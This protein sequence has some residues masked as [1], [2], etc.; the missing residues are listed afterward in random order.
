MKAKPIGDADDMRDGAAEAVSQPRRQQHDVVRPGV[1]NIT[2]ANTMKA[3]EQSTATCSPHAIFGKRLRAPRQQHHGDAADNDD[4][5]GQ[6]QRAEL[7]R[8]TRCSKQ[9]SRRTAPA[10]RTAPPAPP[11][12]HAAAGPRANRRCWSTMAPID[13]QA[14]ERQSATHAISDCQVGAGPLTT[15]SASANSG[16]AAVRLSQA[17]RSNIGAPLRARAAGDC[18]RQS[19]S[20]R[21]SA[22]RR[23]RR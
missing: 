8:R 16:T 9:P 17:N 21:S 15:N 5:A 7:S 4:H 6:P 19:R 14:G 22:P 13:Q 12:S 20:A 11:D 2:M 18:R 10:A 3:I 23:H 1:K